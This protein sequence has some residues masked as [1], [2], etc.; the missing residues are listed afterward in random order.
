MSK[1]AKTSPAS[2]YKTYLMIKKT[3]DNYE[4]LTSITS[5]PDI[6]GDPEMLETTDLEQDAQTFCEGVQQ[7][8]Q[9]QFEA[10]YIKDEYD[11]LRALAHQELE[12]AICFGSNDG[13]DGAWGWNGNISVKAGG[14]GVNEVRKMTITSA[15]YTPIEPVTVTV[16]SV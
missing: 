8:E 1:T 14:A 11:K 15:P 9:L 12:L 3:G 7:I 2:T 4:K 13:V 5:Y 6:G 16:A 10:N